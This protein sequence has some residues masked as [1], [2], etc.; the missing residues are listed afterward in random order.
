MSPRGCRVLGNTSI[1]VK[2]GGCISVQTVYLWLSS[3]DSW[4]YLM[5]MVL[6]ATEKRWLGM[7]SWGR[8]ATGPAQA[9]L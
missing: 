8:S 5:L 2:Q 7:G 9:S 6:K 3:D 4:G 1:L